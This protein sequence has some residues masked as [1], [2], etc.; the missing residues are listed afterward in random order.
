M[1][2]KGNWRIHIQELKRM[3]LQNE[4]GDTVRIRKFLE[5]LSD[6]ELADVEA[7]VY[8]GE[9]GVDYL[10][11]A[12]DEWIKNTTKYPREDLIDNICSKSRNIK[13]RM[14]NAEKIINHDF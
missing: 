6:D 9:H 14:E 13:H 7:L 12:I 2:R 3:V 5:T 8:M 4:E 11:L 10:E 1:S